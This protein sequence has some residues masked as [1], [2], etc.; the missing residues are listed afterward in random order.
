MGHTVV[1]TFSRKEENLFFNKLLT[2][3][4]SKK[5]TDNIFL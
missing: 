4:V 3:T 2:Y 5:V 1:T